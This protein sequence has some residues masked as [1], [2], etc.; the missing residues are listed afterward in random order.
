MN[1]MKLGE[2]CDFKGGSQP[3]KQEWIKEA[4]DGY[5]RMLQIRDF[6]KSRSFDIEYVKKSSKLRYCTKEDILIGRYGASVGK[7][8]TG[9]EGAYNVAIM[10][11]I[12]NEDIIRKEYVR[13]Y[14]ES[15][16]FQIPLLNIC[17]QRAAQAGFSKE[18]IEDFQIPVPSLSEQER[19]VKQL[20]EAFAKIDALKENAQKGLQ[21]VK[22][23]WQATLK[24]ELKPKEG[25]E[26]VSVED[27]AVDIYRGSGIKKDEVTES[28][29]SCVRYGEIYTKYNYS[30][31]SC[32]SHTIEANI[33]SPKYFEN[34]D[35]LFTITGE[36]IDDIAKCIAYIG[37]E[38]C[39]AGGDIVVLK[40]QQE[41]RFL[42]YA[43]MTPDVIKQK[44]LGKTKLKVVHS[45]VPS[46][47]SLKFHL[48]PL[49]KQKK[50][51]DKLDR[52]RILIKEYE[53]FYYQELSEYEALK[54]SIL[55]KAFNSEL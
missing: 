15:P 1:F 38:R 24:E 6:T 53:N 18:D 26:T 36:S 50:I 28:G 37:N 4:N 31:N 14:F 42:S 22:D 39:L 25:W 35:L 8:L 54:Q 11:S 44:G 47:K 17:N 41:P 27:I 48:A 3:P 51:A 13:R 20:D 49:E 30:F 33:K 7:I 55:R 21:A 10:K 16:L 12:P 23:L 40:H 5:V 46:I 45:N 19:I 34:G 32:Y 43:L 2:I 29:I 52:I 9:L